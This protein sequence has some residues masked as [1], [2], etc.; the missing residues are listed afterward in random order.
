MKQGLHRYTIFIFVTISVV[1]LLWWLLSNDDSTLEPNNFVAVSRATIEET[2]TAQGKLE[3]KEF[4]DV[5]A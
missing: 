2:V 1:S 4:V 3:P 5:G